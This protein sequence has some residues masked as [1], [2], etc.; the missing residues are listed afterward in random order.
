MKQTINI[1]ASTLAVAILLLGCAKQGPVNSNDKDKQEIQFRFFVDEGTQIIPYEDYWSAVNGHSRASNSDLPTEFTL[2]GAYNTVDVPDG[3]GVTSSAEAAPENKRFFNGI[4]INSDGTY[5]GDRR[6]W[7]ADGK[8][9]HTFAA[10]AGEGS[11]SSITNLLSQGFTT[12]V[13]IPAIYER[14]ESSPKNQ[15]DL[16]VAYGPTNVIV[17]GVAPIVNIY[18]KHAMAKLLFKI[19]ITGG[20]ALYDCALNITYNSTPCDKIIYYTGKLYSNPGHV[21]GSTYQLNDPIIIPATASSEEN[22]IELGEMKIHS[23]YQSKGWLTLTLTYAKT[24]GGPKTTL[25]TQLPAID[26]QSGI[27]YN[28]FL[29]VSELTESLSITNI[30]VEPW[31]TEIRVADPLD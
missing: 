2:Y 19:S 8:T 30:V 15:K 5:S 21:Y 12:A 16:L 23:Y 31:T 7:V 3:T 1:F 4:K 24:E 27:Q 10:V 17:D 6:Y 9:R 29:Y 11:N 20:T 25:K 28:Y 22:A 13:Y 26:L 18:F 14:M